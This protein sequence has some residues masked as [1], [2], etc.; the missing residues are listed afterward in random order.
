MDINVGYDFKNGELL[1]KKINFFTKE[2]I[3]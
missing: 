2:V 3:S 1:A